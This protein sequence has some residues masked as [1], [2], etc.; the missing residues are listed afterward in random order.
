MKSIRYVET[1]HKDDMEYWDL[2]ALKKLVG[3]NGDV[4]GAQS[5]RNYG[6]SYAGMQFANEFLEKGLN[7]AWG[8]YNKP[9][10]ATSLQT[11]KTFNPLLKEVSVKNSNGQTYL[12]DEST[13]GKILFFSWS[14]AQNLKGIDEPYE[15]MI[16]DEFIPERYT[17]KTRMDTEFADYNSVFKSIA[18]SYGT[19]QMFFSN[20]IYWFNPFFIGWGLPP[21]GKGKIAVMDDRFK[22]EIDGHT[23]K[24]ERRVVW[25]NVAGTHAIIQRNLKQSSLEFGT[26]SELTA[27]FNN[28]TKAEYTTIEKCPDMSRPLNNIQFMTDG[29]YFGFRMCNGMAYFTKINPS[30]DIDTYVSEPAYIDIRRRHYRNAK[31]GVELEEMFNNAQCAFNSPE[32]LTAFLRFIRHLRGRV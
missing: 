20:C 27:Y 18:R 5:T 24:T 19:K 28:E 30:L 25:E 26:E 3:Y 2:R 8:R 4:V 14:V 23:F 1:N 16:C 15:W 17:A 13:G 10:L 9:E 29:Y 32:T 11:W 31:M 6:K 7:V 12:I 21:F 22:V